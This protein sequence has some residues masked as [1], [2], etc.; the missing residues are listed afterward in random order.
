MLIGDFKPTGLRPNFA[1]QAAYF[2]LEDS[3]LQALD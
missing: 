1:K 3:L 2:G